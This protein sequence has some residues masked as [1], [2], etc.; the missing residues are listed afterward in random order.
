MSISLSLR[1]RL[2]LLVALPTPR[3]CQILCILSQQEDIDRI[4]AL[5]VWIEAERRKRPARLSKRAA[6]RL[7]KSLFPGA[8]L[9]RLLDG[10]CWFDPTVFELVTE[11]LLSPVV[12]ARGQTP[13]AEQLLEIL[14]G[15]SAGDNHP[16]F[17]I[18]SFVEALP[19]AAQLSK[20]RGVDEP[21][22]RR[23]QPHK[24]VA[25]LLHVLLFLYQREF[26]TQTELINLF[27]S[28]LNSQS[29]VWK[30]VARGLKAYYAEL[31]KQS[32]SQKD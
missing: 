2:D 7:K 10:E 11:S 8:S 21:P 23:P 18:R 28:H 12:A 22:L 30:R 27:G 4:W 19:E 32:L 29:S 20:V 9:Q 15:W 31:K 14:E 13:D 16:F 17:A 3:L 1:D 6:A 26:V 5:L 25:Q 24:N